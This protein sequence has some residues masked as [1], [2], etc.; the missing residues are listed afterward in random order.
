MTRVAATTL[1]LVMAFASPAAGHGGVTLTSA[2][3]EGLSAQLTGATIPG[4]QSPDGRS[5]VDYT[6]TVRA[7]R[8]PV[9]DAGVTLAIDRGNGRIEERTA[10]AV[11]GAF[12]VLVDPEDDNWRRWPARLTVKREGVSLSAAYQPPDTSAPSWLPFLAVLLV[13]LVIFAGSRMIR[14]SGEA[15]GS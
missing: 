4:D 8:R 2:S 9:T 6:V 1:L 13:P 5:R 3:G 15:S 14:K 7:G 11:D 10:K 12:E